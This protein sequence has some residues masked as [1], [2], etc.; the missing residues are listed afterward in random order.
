MDPAKSKQNDLKQKT[1][2]GFFNRPAPSASSGGKSSKA[3]PK[4]KL[5]HL[6][7]P[8]FKGKNRDE[9]DEYTNARVVELSSSVTSS[10]K[11]S[12]SRTSSHGI[13]DTP[14][15][16]DPVDVD[17]LSDLT[18]LT[19]DEIKVLEKPVRSRT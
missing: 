11:S 4:A 15:T 14:P 10:F 2:L 18:D 5:A 12:G 13:K 19:D 17:M 3:V 7:T 9:D 6:H 16:S 1:L 8:P